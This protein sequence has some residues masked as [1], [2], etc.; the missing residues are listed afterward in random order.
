MNFNKITSS[1]NN[2]NNIISATTQL[3]NSQQQQLGSIE[4]SREQRSSSFFQQLAADKPS[5]LSL[6]P[7]LKVIKRY[8]QVVA[9]GKIDDIEAVVGCEGSLQATTS[10]NEM[11][12]RKK[13]FKMAM[14]FERAAVVAGV[15]YGYLMTT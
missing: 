9:E 2:N 10:L 4:G 5:L 7:I 14:Y 1:N 3:P 6:T 15:C 11:I 12:G 13:I 8:L